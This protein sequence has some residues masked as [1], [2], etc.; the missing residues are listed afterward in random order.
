MVR[1][2][3]GVMQAQVDRHGKMYRIEDLDPEFVRERV[4]VDLYREF[5]G[6]YVKNAYDPE[7][8]PETPTISA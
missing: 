6:R 2:A 5:A 1:D 7:A 8:T 3:A 4:D